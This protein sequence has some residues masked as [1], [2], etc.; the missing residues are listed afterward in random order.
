[1]LNIA[2]RAVRETISKKIKGSVQTTVW[3]TQKEKIFLEEKCE[4]F[5]RILT[6]ITGLADIEKTIRKQLLKFL[7]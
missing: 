1:M 6:A 5:L 3:P 7:M 4:K 2:L